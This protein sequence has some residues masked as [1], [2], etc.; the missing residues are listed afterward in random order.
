MN[1]AFSIYIPTTIAIISICLNLYQYVNKRKLLKP[2]LEFNKIQYMRTN[3]STYINLTVSNHSDRNVSIINVSIGNKH[4]FTKT[5]KVY[6][7]R[8]SKDGTFTTELPLVIKSWESENMLVEVLTKTGNE[9]K[10]ETDFE[11]YEVN[12]STAECLTPEQILKEW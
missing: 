5:H 3:V 11:P 9:V 10:I 7:P 4:I 6:G 2:N 12:L 8:D 1:T